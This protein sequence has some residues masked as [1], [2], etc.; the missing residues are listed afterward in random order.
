VKITKSKVEA[1]T[2]PAFGST[3][4]WD[5]DLPGF[6]VRVWASGKRSYIVQDRAKGKERRVT[7]GQHG[8]PLNETETLTADKARKMAMGLISSFSEGVDPVDEKKRKETITVTLDDVADVYLKERKTK[9]GGE[10]T[11]RT[12]ADIQRHIDY[13]FAD[14]KEKPV[15]SI[16]RDMCSERFSE[17]SEKGP[18]QANQAFRILRSLLNFAREAYRPGGIPILLENPVAVLSGKKMWNPNNARNGRI[19]LDKVGASWN[20]LQDRRTSEAVLASSKTGADIV[21]F[22]L[23][24]GCRWSEAAQLTWPQVKFEG[25][26]FHLPDPKNHLP[27]TFPM[28]APLIEMLVARKGKKIKGN[29]YVFNARNKEGKKYL[30]NAAPTMEKIS[31][32]AGMHLTPHDLRRTFISIGIKLK[33]EMWKLKLLTNHV[34]QDDVTITNY[35]EKSDLTYLSGE[36][37]QIA[38]WIMEQGKIAAGANII[39]LR[40]VAA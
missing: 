40:E 29:P 21:L 37:E 33:I 15:A 6:G 9:K 7:I 8:K 1:L 31:K 11:P 4:H 20:L 3:L 30:D 38:A 24:T 32:I 27:V 19:P 14:W 25:A 13:S 22:L 10:L 2:I 26:T 23:L 35:T 39:P 36:A 28:S 34:I 18:T 5:D 12:K 17:L 16:T